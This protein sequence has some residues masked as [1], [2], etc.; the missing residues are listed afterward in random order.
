MRSAGWCSLL[1]LELGACGARAERPPAQA[2]E[3]AETDELPPAR[4]SSVASAEARPP[5]SS[6]DAVPAVDLEGGGEDRAATLPADGGSPE[7][8]EADAAPPPAGTFDNS[9]GMRFVSVPG[10]KVRFSIWETRVRDYEAYAVATGA[11]VPHPEFPEAALQPKASISRKEAEAFAAWLTKKERDEKRIGASAEY[12]LPT[13]AEWDVAIEVGK[14]GGPFPWGSG[15][16]PPDHFAN[17]GVTKDGFAYT[18][19]VG[20]F[21]PNSLGLYDM[22]GNLWEW[23]GQGCASGGAFLVR[24]AGWNA[25]NQS[26]FN[27]GFHYCFGG[28]L[29]GHHNVGFR[30][31]LSEP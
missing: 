15:F 7:V 2:A 6:S 16:P 5:T 11:L 22:A 14:T 12:R 26:Y 20:S 31:V 4:D 30:L 1:F 23:I 13:D 17:Y 29:V 18:A 9:L 28:D 10:L 24:G 25:K 27:L 3:D 8:A 19:P 21:P